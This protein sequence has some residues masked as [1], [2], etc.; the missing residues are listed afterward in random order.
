MAL[1]NFF[2]V[3]SIVFSDEKIKFKSSMKRLGDLIYDSTHTKKATDF[4]DC[5][6]LCHCNSSVYSEFDSFALNRRATALAS[7]TA[8]NSCGRIYSYFTLNDSNQSPFRCF[9]GFVS[10]KYSIFDGK[11]ISCKH[12]LDGLTKIVRQRYYLS[13]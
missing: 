13:R 12:E 6:V 2:P 3:T 4:C 7:F 5:Y 10:K 9:P 1:A 11:F 8:T